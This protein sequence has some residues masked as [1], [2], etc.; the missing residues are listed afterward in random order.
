MKSI[1]FSKVKNIFFTE[2]ENPLSIEDLETIQSFW[3]IYSQD[4][5]HLFNG[6]IIAIES[7][8]LE[9]E[10]ASLKWFKSNYAHYLIRKHQISTV[11]KC[12]ILFCS[13]VL[14]TSKG[15]IV[16]GKMSATTSSKGKILLPGGNIELLNGILDFEVCK[17]N[18]VRELKEEIGFSLS[19]KEIELWQIKSDGEN[20]NVGLLFISKRKYSEENILKSF[21]QLLTIEEKPEL[22]EIYFVNKVED[23]SKVEQKHFVDYVNLVFQNRYNDG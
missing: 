4:K 21:S 8:Y 11:P 19:S 2:I 23:F 22:S 6:N 7:I 3:E 20:G 14:E 17:Q 18:A 9:N 16:L 5:A 13:V 12:K 10:I 1:Q 15:N